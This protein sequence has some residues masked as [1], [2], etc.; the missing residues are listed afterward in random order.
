MSVVDAVAV[1][2]S[3][4]SEVSVSSTLALDMPK[5]SKWTCPCSSTRRLAGFTSR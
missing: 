3:V 4:S 2:A 5:S 1:R